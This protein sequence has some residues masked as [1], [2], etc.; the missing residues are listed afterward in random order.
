MFSFLK[1]R[2][3]D[4]RSYGRVFVPQGR[5]RL[6]VHSFKT[7][8]RYPLDIVEIDPAG[9]RFRGQ[10]MTRLLKGESVDVTLLGADAPLV[11]SGEVIWVKSLGRE[12]EGGISFDAVSPADQGRIARLVQRL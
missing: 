11:L 4:R 6:E 9:V 12:Y 7:R 5:L 10:A 3:D 1:S 2:P 8:E